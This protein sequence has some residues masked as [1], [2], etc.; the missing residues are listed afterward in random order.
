MQSSLI[1]SGYAFLTRLACSEPE[2]NG[3]TSIE[4]SDF[5]L[6]NPYFFYSY[7]SISKSSE[8]L[9]IN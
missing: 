8:F 5:T 1:M 4:I 3:A 6:L 7:F 9:M 2:I